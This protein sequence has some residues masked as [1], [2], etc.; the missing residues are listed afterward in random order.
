MV[1]FLVFLFLDALVDLFAV[2]SDFLRRVHANA[3]LI[4]LD[5]QHSHSDVITNH[6]GLSDPASQN[7]HSFLLSCFG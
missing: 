6:Q 5:A 7:Q 1:W 2:N 3:H 4:S